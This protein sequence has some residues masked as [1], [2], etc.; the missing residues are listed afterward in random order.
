MALDKAGYIGLLDVTLP[1]DSDSRAEGA[2]QLRNLKKA[3]K[4]SFPNFDRPLQSTS[5]Q[6]NNIVPHSHFYKGQVIM[7]STPVSTE[8]PLG[9]VF[10]DGGNIDYKPIII[11]DGEFSYNVKTA[12]SVGGN[13]EVYSNFKNLSNVVSFT[14]SS[15]GVASLRLSTSTPDLTD[16]LTVTINGITSVMEKTGPFRYES[17]S[18]FVFDFN[19]NL[20]TSWLTI[21][22]RIPNKVVNGVTI[23][24]LRGVTPR[25]AT[26]LTE[27]PHYGGHASH[28]LAH[29]FR[30][31]GHKLDLTEYPSH[32]H[33]FAERTGAIEAQDSRDWFSPTWQGNPYGNGYLGPDGAG[34]GYVG[35]N[36]NEHFHGMVEKSELDLRFKYAKIKYIIYVGV[37]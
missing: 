14:Q 36:N 32:N 29:H 17:T 33:R 7:F 5:D 10:C 2:G 20:E 6:L 19:A 15:S 34:I 23:P 12:D 24:D 28:K 21:K 13:F 18:K 4:N 16:S 25:G 26:L 31:E 22:T 3:L 11:A 30:M 8:T 1:R 37:A 27:K 9:W 35:Y